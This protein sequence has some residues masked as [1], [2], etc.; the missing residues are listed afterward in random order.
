MVDFVQKLAA[1]V[2][3][4]LLLLQKAAV[5]D[6]WDSRSA[7]VQSFL[8]ANNKTPSGSPARRQMK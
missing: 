2:P 5:G 8:S 6:K 3:E 1:R 7:V 4:K